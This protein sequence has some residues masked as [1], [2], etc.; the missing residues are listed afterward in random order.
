MS[1]DSHCQ[2]APPGREAAQRRKTPRQQRGQETLDALVAA[3]AALMDEGDY[4]QLTTKAIAARAGTSIGSFYQFFANKEGVVNE[5][6]QR[7]RGQVRAYLAGSVGDP[8]HDGISSAW[9]SQIILGLGQIYRNMPGFRGVWSGRHRSGP[10]G[11]QARALR[12]EVFDALDQTLGDA[13]PH[14][15]VEARQR[16]LGIALE[17]AYQLLSNVDDKRLVFE[18]LQRMLGPYLASYFSAAPEAT[19]ASTTT[20]VSRSGK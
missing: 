12:Q 8:R 15:S 10:L 7:Y 9:V 18:E 6:V 16:S 14:V 17:T 20:L 4:E 5:L 11:E 2:E 13:F 3:T 19:V 1:V